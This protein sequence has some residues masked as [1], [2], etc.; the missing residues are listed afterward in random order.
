M[1]G[2]LAVELQAQKS[3]AEILQSI[4]QAAADIVPGASWAGISVI[5]GK[6]AVAKVP[7]SRTVAELDDLQ[8]ALDEGPCLTA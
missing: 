3:T 8:A 5:E 4:V 7:A 1:F 2:N 6:K